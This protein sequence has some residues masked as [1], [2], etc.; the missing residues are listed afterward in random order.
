MTDYIVKSDDSEYYVYIS[1]TE[2]WS[3]TGCA[4]IAHEFQTFE[5]AE[6]MA[7]ELNNNPLFKNYQMRVESVAAVGVA[8][9]SGQPMSLVG[10]LM[11]LKLKRI[12]MLNRLSYLRA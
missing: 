6:D 10:A 7:K 8:Q 3:L 1:K 2:G 11:V 12:F 9:Q 4:E 5:D